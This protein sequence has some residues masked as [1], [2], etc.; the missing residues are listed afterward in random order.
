MQA[1]AFSPAHITGFFEMKLSKY[2]PIYSGSNGAGFSTS[3]GVETT[4]DA[5]E[6]GGPGFKIYLNGKPAHNVPVSSHILSRFLNGD[7]RNIS[8]RVNHKVDVPMGSGF[9]SSGAGGLSL[10]LA[11]NEVLDMGLSRVEAAGIAHEAEIV[12][13]TGLGTVI[14]EDE[15][16]F[17]VRTAP[18]APGIG[19]VKRLPINDNHLMVALHFGP[20]STPEALTNPKYISKINGIGN[21]FVD[22]LTLNPSVE[23]FMKLSRRFAE[24]CGFVTRRMRS[25]MKEASSHGFVSSMAMFGETVFSLVRES[26]S[27]DLSRIFQRHVSGDSSILTAHID[28]LGARIL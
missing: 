10:S 21:R 16:G 2:S 22:L 13:K 20:I 24:S 5:E 18:G 19:K 28:S 25:A 7:N 9:G 4:V 8:V 6:N 23:E 3:L 14:A 27:S 15:G 26:E 17:E 11:L 1:S 12:S